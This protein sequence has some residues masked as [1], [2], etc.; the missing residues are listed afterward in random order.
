MKIKELKKEDIDEPENI[1]MK[2]ISFEEVSY[3]IK[4]LINKKPILLKINKI[5]KGAM[6]LFCLY[7]LISFELLMKH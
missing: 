7:Y 4:K 3:A 2:E 1:K 6:P 5:K